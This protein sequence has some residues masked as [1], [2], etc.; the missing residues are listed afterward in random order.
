[1]RAFATFFGGTFGGAILGG[2]TV[3]FFHRFLQDL[4]WPLNEAFIGFPIG[5]VLGFAAGGIQWSRDRNRSSLVE[6]FAQVNGY[7]FGE[8]LV[9]SG[10]AGG[11]KNA[12]ILKHWHKARNCVEG[13]YKGFDFQMFDLTRI[14]HSTSHSPEHGRTSSTSYPRQT[15]II[16][17]SL[18]LVTGSIKIAHKRRFRRITETVVP[19]LK[20]DKITID[21]S[22]YQA[23]IDR[24]SQKYSITTTGTETRIGIS[25]LEQLIRGR[26]WSIEQEDSRAIFYV[27]RKLLPPT[28]YKSILDEVKH[29]IGRLSKNESEARITLTPRDDTARF[30]TGGIVRV[31]LGGAG[32]LMFSFALFIPLFFSL[33]PKFPF[34]LF[35]WPILGMASAIG[36][37]FLATR[38]GRSSN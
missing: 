29:L 38:I 33:A 12:T 1:M 2:L 25:L 21:D 7:R 13:S 36:G 11:T 3:L 35:L 22:R 9:K 18:P 27:E 4:P 31:F 32:G 5:A 23:D 30:S 26:G 20:G 8:T 17:H 6:V 14:I 10:V 16:V 28:D 19:A 37:I 24:F 15:V 34:V